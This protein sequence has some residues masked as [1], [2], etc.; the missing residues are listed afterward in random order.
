MDAQLLALRCSTSTYAIDNGFESETERLEM[1]LSVPA[2]KHDML[3]DWMNCDGTKA[4]LVALL[5]A[6][7]KVRDEEDE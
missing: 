4:G 7:R 3:W 1:I 5:E 6:K 2:Y